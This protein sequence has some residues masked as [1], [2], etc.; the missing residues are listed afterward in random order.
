MTT[1]TY[2]ERAERCTNY[3]TTL[4][5]CEALFKGLIHPLRDTQVN[6]V[7]VRAA[8]LVSTVIAT[9][10]SRLTQ[11][12]AQVAVMV[13]AAVKPYGVNRE[14]VLCGQN[15]ILF[16]EDGE[17]DKETPDPCGLI[18]EDDCPL[19]D[20]EAAALALLAERDGLEQEIQ[21][22]IKAN[23]RDAKR[24]AQLTATQRTPGTVEVCQRYVFHDCVNHHGHLQWKYGAKACTYGTC[25][26]RKDAPN[27]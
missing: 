18:H 15:D 19:K 1:P 21:N 25:P 27:V 26:I 17:Y 12:D 20:V 14:C 11:R 3:V 9:L 23:T 4:A 13:E 6:D 22:Y 2:E 10:K 16:T 8:N 7:P 24:I 5:E